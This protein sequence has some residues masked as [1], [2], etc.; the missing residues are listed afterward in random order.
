M[1]SNILTLVSVILFTVSGCTMAPKYVRPEALVPSTWPEGSAYAETKTNTTET[2]QAELMDW[3]Q[4]YTDEKLQQVIA[5]ALENNRDLRLAAENVELARAIYGI[6]RDAIYPTVNLSAG[7]SKQQAAENLTQS[8]NSRTSERYDVN[9]GTIAWEI[10]FFGRIRSL[11][12]RALAEYLATEQARRSA[13][14]MLISSIAG[15]YTA[16]AADRTNLALAETTLETQ[17]AACNLIQRQYEVGIATELDLRQAQIPMYSAKRDIA[18][19]VQLTSQDINALT[20]LAG[21]PVPE[22]LL[23][24]GIDQIQPPAPLAPGLSSEVLLQRPDVMQSEY[25]LRAAHA[26]IGAAR[27]ALF[28]RISLTGLLGF[29]SKDLSRLF[30]SGNGTWSFAPQ[31]SLPVFDTRAWSALKA[32]KVQMQIAVTSYEKSIQTAFREIADA[33]ALCGTMDQQTEAQ[34]ALVE[35][36]EITHRLAKARYESGV[37]SYLPVLDAQ[38]SLMAAQQGLVS[39]R[40][41]QLTSQ[42]RLFAVLGGGCVTSGKE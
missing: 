30:D 29:A 7:G 38:R 32:S 23:A 9:L 2:A 40:Q 25:M 12:D 28:P 15:T 34:T 24:S 3:R 42:M 36:L 33:L 8:G 35:A 17:Q 1:K 31:A 39:L 6:Q 16:L 5:L 10:D 26:N 41:T 4:F 21:S 18:R 19:Y 13:E 20:L 37:D 14:I 22:D 11:K 27:A